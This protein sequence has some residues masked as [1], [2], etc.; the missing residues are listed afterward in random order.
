MRSIASVIEKLAREVLRKLRLV[1]SPD[2]VNWHDHDM[3]DVRDIS[4]IFTGHNSG[5][6][7][8]RRLWIR[9]RKKIAK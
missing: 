1:S 6:H 8:R 4:L 9:K 2:T 7:L 5:R 3:I